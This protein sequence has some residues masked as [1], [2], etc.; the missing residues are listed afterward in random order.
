MGYEFVVDIWVTGECDHEA[1]IK[2]SNQQ[3][4]AGS[5]ATLLSDLSQLVDDYRRRFR[6]TT[7][8]S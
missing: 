1:L 2:K 7:T 5:E 4:V 8:T 6:R 3:T